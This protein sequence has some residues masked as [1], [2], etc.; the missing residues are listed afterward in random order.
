VRA[1][2]ALGRFDAAVSGALADV[3]GGVGEVHVAQAE[4]EQLVEL[5]LLL[6]YD[7][8]APLDDRR[9]P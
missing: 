9:R 4:S 7:G 8:Q 1:G 5:Q 2:A 6:G 3:D